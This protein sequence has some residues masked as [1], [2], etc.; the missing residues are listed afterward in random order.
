MQQ[1][2]KF[3]ALVGFDPG[4]K[5]SIAY[6]MRDGDSYSLLSLYDMP[7]CSASSDCIFDAKRLSDIL[8]EERREASRGKY[9]LQ[10]T[11]EDVYLHVAGGRKAA[12]GFGYGLGILH[13]VLGS[14]GIKFGVIQPKEWKKIFNIKE[15]EEAIEISYKH[16]KN[17]T[18]TIVVSS[19][20]KKF[21]VDHA[22]SMLIAIAESVANNSK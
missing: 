6:V 22:E 20:P 21:R 3:Y 9:K 1:H 14:L 15:K 16:I 19:A 5:G 18:E 2:G 17:I 12:F 10:Y 4:R 7:L 13:G 8:K 11:I